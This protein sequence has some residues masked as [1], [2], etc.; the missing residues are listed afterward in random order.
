MDLGYYEYMDEKRWR[1]SIMI[2]CYLRFEMFVIWMDENRYQVWL[3]VEI[4]VCEVWVEF[5]VIL[6]EDVKVM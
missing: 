5:G 1:M 4:L 3:E 6:K 2:E